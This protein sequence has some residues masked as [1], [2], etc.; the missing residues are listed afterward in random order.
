MARRNTFAAAQAARGPAT[1]PFVG[2]PTTEARAVIALEEAN[3]RQEYLR[4]TSERLLAGV[5][6]AIICG[7]FVYPD[8]LRNELFRV[9]REGVLVGMKAEARRRN[10]KGARSW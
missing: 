1:I 5:G 9:Y 3:A 7:N 4:V 8:R 10:K 2:N 6:N